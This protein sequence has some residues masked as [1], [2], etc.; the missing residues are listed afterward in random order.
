MIRVLTPA[1]LQEAF[2]LLERHPDAV[3]V[4]GGTDLFVRRRGAGVPDARPLLAVS[5]LEE[6]GG[7]REEGAHLA[8]GAATP[9]SRICLDPLVLAHA[10]LLARAAR[11]VGGPAIRNMA[12]IGGNI[13]TASPAAD[14]LPPLYLLDARIEI[15]S[16][17]T[18]RTLPIGEFVLG[19][20]KTAL[21]HGE[22]ITRVLLPSGN[23]TA[24]SVQCF[25]KV[26]RRESLAIS[27]TSFCGVVRM[28]GDGTIE[29]AR[30]AW[31]S[32]GPTVVRLP[33]LEKTLAGV[34]P[35]REIVDR[36]A[37]MARDGVSPI[38]DI[39]AS[40]DYRRRVAGNLL[41]RFLEGL[42]G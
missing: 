10:P 13:H 29:A 4:A 9:F 12:T 25:E 24:D 39:R 26:G 31:G 40:A 21:R 41:V 20:G 7:I 27:V 2:L 18:T 36:A 8:I 32:V 23:Q 42:R 5:R 38:S 28:A 19:P 30:F 16:S 1:D 35:E 33:M 11:A 17:Q 15:A 3:P 37:R 6:L 34:R 22:L 14:S